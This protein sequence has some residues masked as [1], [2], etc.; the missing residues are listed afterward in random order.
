MLDLNGVKAQKLG[1]KH[2][3][4]SWIPRP[5]SYRRPLCATRTHAPPRLARHP[6]SR[7]RGGAQRVYNIFYE[8]FF[9]P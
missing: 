6:D 1:K 2:L 9:A 5:V 8:H 3:R 4:G 7:A